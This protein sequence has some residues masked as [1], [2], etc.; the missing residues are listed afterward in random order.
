MLEF[1]KKFFRRNLTPIDYSKVIEVGDTIGFTYAS[2]YH[3]GIVETILNLNESNDDVKYVIKIT[4]DD[5]P[6][7]FSNWIGRTEIIDL[8]YT[9]WTIIKKYN[10]TEIPVDVSFKNK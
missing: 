6:R 9:Y 1:V 8:S 10:V 3:E 2:Y 5:S 4:R 7:Y